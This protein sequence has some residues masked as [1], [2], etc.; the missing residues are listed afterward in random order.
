MLIR[1]AQE[2]DIPA[3][4]DLLLQVLRV[5]HE[6]RPDLF[7]PEARKYTDDQL[8]EILKDHQDRKEKN[9]QTRCRKEPLCV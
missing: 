7:K 3:I 6:G 2:K 5:H 4:H 9:H 8:R 1:R